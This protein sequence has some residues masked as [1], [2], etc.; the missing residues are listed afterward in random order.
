MITRLLHTL[1]GHPWPQCRELATPHA[2]CTGCKRRLD[3]QTSAQ[4]F[5]RRALD[6]YDSNRR[7]P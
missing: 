2:W 3:L 5:A 1:F 7:A 6:V 4:L